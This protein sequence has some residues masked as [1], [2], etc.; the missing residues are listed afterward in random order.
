[1]R[2]PAANVIG[3]PGEG[4][5]VAN[6]SLAAERGG[7]GDLASR[8]LIVGLIDLARAKRHGTGSAI[9]DGAVRQAIATLAVRARIQ[10]AL[11]NKVLTRLLQGVDDRDRRAR[12]EGVGRAS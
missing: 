3:S 2:V 4:W 9:D 6:T 11:G 5:K 1:V 8:E 10:T 12:H 7:V